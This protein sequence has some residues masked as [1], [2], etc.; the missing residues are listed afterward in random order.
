MGRPE[1]EADLDIID[2]LGR[3]PSQGNTADR[4]LASLQAQHPDPKAVCSPMTQVPVEVTRRFHVAPDTPELPHRF[5]IA[6]EYLQIQEVMR[7]ESL[8]LESDRL[9][10]LRDRHGL[11]APSPAPP[12]NRLTLAAEMGCDFEIAWLP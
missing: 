7:R 3:E 10:R 6:M 4:P 5:R 2:V 1:G 8:A 9:K 11:A 12:P